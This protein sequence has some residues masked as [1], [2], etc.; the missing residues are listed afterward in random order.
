MNP[1]DGTDTGT[2]P[3]R[4]T[5]WHRHRWP[6]RCLRVGRWMVYLVL[7]AVAAF[8]LY[9]NRVGIP[10]SLKDRLLVTLRE[11]GVEMQFERIRFRT[12]RGIVAE[13]VTLGRRGDLGGEQFRAEEVQLGLDW[14]KVLTLQPEVTGL[15]IRQGAVSIPLVESNRVVT[16]FELDGVEALL[17][18]E[19]PE[20]WVVED[21]QARTGVGSLRASGVLENPS[22]F[23]ARPGPGGA[24]APGAWR[25]TLLRV[26]RTL[27]EFGFRT[28]A[29]IG[30]RFQSDLNRPAESSAELTLSAGEV[31]WKGRS[32]ERLSLEARASPQAGR[33]GHLALGARW[34]VDGIV[35]DE[36][37]LGSLRGS[38][39]LV[40][41]VDA[42]L[43]DRA[44]WRLDLEGLE[45][46]RLRLAGVTLEGVS[47]RSASNTVPL[48]PWDPRQPMRTE[49]QPAPRFESTVR[50]T[51]R[52]VAAGVPEIRLAEA[53]AG[54]VVDHG[55]LGW[56]RARLDLR[57]PGV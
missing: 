9:L 54:L 41:P 5:I 31:S 29:E 34:T 7:A 37:N 2:G 53:S 4:R 25:S 21:L 6:R 40:Q 23:R 14:W 39:D 30:L 52:G 32:F 33:P 56:H 11:R 57:S 8:V 15:R 13:R 12:T 35:A 38:V 10:E 49:S 20:R 3:G 36:G 43:P 55:L 45:T 17:R 51:V 27:E 16:R 48:H 44:D 24:D 47:V 46:P 18:L 28:P 1:V 42:V 50:L 26:Q 19:G 22:R